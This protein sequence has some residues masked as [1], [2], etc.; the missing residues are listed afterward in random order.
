MSWMA[1]S[2]SFSSNTSSSS[3]GGT[4]VV[5]SCDSFGAKPSSFSRYSRRAIGSRSVR[6]AS[7]RYDERSR[8]ASRSVDVAL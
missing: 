3:P 2:S 8:L 5:A 4:F 1:S 6:N 7:F